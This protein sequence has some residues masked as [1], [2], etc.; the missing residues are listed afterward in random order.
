[1]NINVVHLLWLIPLSML[2]G[3]GVY[4]FGLSSGLIKSIVFG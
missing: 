1:M 4:F 3:V 2:G